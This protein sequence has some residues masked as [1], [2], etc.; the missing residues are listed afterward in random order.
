MTRRP[1]SPT[2]VAAL[3]IAPVALGSCGGSGE[4]VARNFEDMHALLEGVNEDPSRTAVAQILDDCA[5]D[6]REGKISGF[7]AAMFKTQLATAAKDG[8]I[9]DPEVAHLREQHEEM[10][11][12]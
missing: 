12:E 8:V 10:I 4:I 2:L 5:R 9:G 11:E 7:E 6:A 3:V 1:W